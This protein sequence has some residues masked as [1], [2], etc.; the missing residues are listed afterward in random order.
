VQDD[1][2]LTDKAYKRIESDI[3]LFLNRVKD[4]GVRFWREE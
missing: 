2:I 3:Q 1:F 4:A